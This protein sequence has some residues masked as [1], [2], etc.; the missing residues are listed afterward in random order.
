MG[1][2]NMEYSF[3]S[4]KE[5]KDFVLSLK[6]IGSTWEISSILQLLTQSKTN[7]NLKMFIL[8][9][10]KPLEGVGFLETRGS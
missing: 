5:K 7:K 3:G 6:G 4:K 2:A 1:S 9:V 10:S 8:T